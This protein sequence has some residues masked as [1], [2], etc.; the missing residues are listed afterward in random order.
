MISKRKI[1]EIA[2]KGVLIYFFI[3]IIINVIK[4]L[5]EYIEGVNEYN[6]TNEQIIGTFFL[7]ILMSI[8][9]AIVSNFFI[10]LIY[11][12]IKI[13]NKTARND[14]LNKIDLGKYKGYYREIINEYSPAVLSFIYDFE[15]DYKKDVVA[16]ILDLKLKNNVELN[17]N[18][19]KVNIIRETR[20]IDYAK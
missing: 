19:I 13:A 2:S 3:A 11:I 17:D 10:I 18:K 15:L 14:I 4:F 6:L 7:M 1:N 9:G 20:A 16:T 12:A 8:V 5:P